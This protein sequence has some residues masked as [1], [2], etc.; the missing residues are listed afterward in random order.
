MPK[1]KKG[2]RPW[3]PS[4]ESQRKSVE[5]EGNSQ[6]EKLLKLM[7]SNGSPA[8]K[9]GVVTSRLTA[10]PL[11]KENQVYTPSKL[12]FSTPKKGP[13][14]R[15][16]STPQGT[17]LFPSRILTFD[18]GET[19]LFL[20]AK[21]VGNQSLQIPFPNAWLPSSP[22]PLASMDGLID[23][24]I[25]LKTIQQVDKLKRERKKKGEN[26]RGK[27]QN[28]I[29]HIS[30]ANALKFAGI[31]FPDGEAQWLH[32]GPHSCLGDDS[33]CVTNIGLGTR[34]ANAAME[35]VNP[36]LRSMLREYK[37]SLP[38]IYLSAQ[39]EWVPGFE[40]I[41]LLKSITLIIKD[42][43]GTSFTRKA[44]IKFNTLSLDPVCVSE[45][46]LI[47][48][49]LMQKFAPV[50]VKTSTTPQKKHQH[51]ETDTPTP[52][53]AKTRHSLSV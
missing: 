22:V 36:V 30:A 16:V 28:D 11:G 39:P 12:T 1:N 38:I 2:D 18:D 29:M 5:V 9:I 46:S 33:Q 14:S 3:H 53:R 6:V 27:S 7:Q 52:K 31:N 15:E 32:L 49:A 41:R 34:S 4:Q 47:K 23:V 13:R 43:P 35:L 37:D 44:S 48:N 51:S 45:I 20:P 26:P 17:N 42:G 24:P 25:T 40:R 19:T 50:N 10:P 21:K 8:E